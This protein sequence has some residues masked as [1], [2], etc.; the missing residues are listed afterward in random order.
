MPFNYHTVWL[1]LD[2]H[3]WELANDNRF[4]DGQMEAN[5][6]ALMVFNNIKNSLIYQ[7]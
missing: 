6:C 1:K 5:L 2:T 4:D 7:H 3:H